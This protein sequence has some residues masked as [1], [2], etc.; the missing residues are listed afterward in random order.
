MKATRM[1]GSGSNGGQ[2]TFWPAMRLLQVVHGVGDVGG[3]LHHLR[4]R[5]AGLGADPLD[6]MRALRR[7]GDVELHALEIDLVGLRLG[8]RDADVMEFFF[9]RVALRA[10]LMLEFHARIGEAQAVVVVEAGVFADD[11]A[12]RAAHHE[13]FGGDAVEREDVAGL[14]LRCICS[15]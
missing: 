5:T 8:G 14:A 7:V 4:E 15:R 11:G 3:G 10:G 13:V 9:M 12:G 1:P 2:I 6:A